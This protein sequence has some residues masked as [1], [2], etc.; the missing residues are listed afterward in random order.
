MTDEGCQT[1]ELDFP[2]S[3]PLPEQTATNVEMAQNGPEPTVTGEVVYDRQ[4]MVDHGIQGD[5]HNQW[6]TAAPASLP[7]FATNGSLSV[8]DSELPVPAGLVF[9][10]PSGDLEQGWHPRSPVLPSEGYQHTSEPLHAPHAFAGAFGDERPLETG[11]I[12]SVSHPRSPSEPNHLAVE[13]SGHATYDHLPT[14]EQNY[15]VPTAPQDMA[16]PPLD[17]ETEEGVSPAEQETST[18]YPPDYLDDD[19]PISRGVMDVEQNPFG[20]RPPVTADV[21]SSSWAPINNPTRATSMPRTD[22]LG[23]G[24]GQSPETAV[25][26]DE[27]DSD[28]DPPPPTAVEDTVVEGR[29]HALGVYEEAEVEDEVDAEYS[30]EDEPEYDADEMGGDYDTRNYVGPN[31][32]EDD[33]HDEDLRPHNLEPEFNDGESWEGVDEDEDEM[34]GADGEDYSEYESDYEMEYEMDEADENPQQP[35]RPVSQSTPQVIDLIS[36]SED[37][38]DDDQAAPPQPLPRTNI[39][40]PSRYQPKISDEVLARGGGDEESEE[41]EDSEG[42]NEEKDEAVGKEEH[43]GEQDDAESSHSSD[44]SELQSSAS[45]EASDD[46]VIDES[47]ETELEQAGDTPV[48]EVVEDPDMDPES[49]STEFQGQQA[50]ESTTEF[51]KSPQPNGVQLIAIQDDENDTAMGGVEDK[52][53]DE[54]IATPQ[55]AAEGLEFLSRIVEN[56]L[57]ANNETASSEKAQGETAVAATSSEADAPP[58]AHAQGTR[59]QVDGSQVTQEEEEQVDMISTLPNAPSALQPTV[60]DENKHTETVAPSSPPLTSSFVSQLGEES[61]VE[62]APQDAPPTTEPQIP[63]DQ[64]PTPLDTQLTGDFTV[65][66]PLSVSMEIEEPEEITTTTER[67]ETVVREVVTEQS[68]DVQEPLVTIEETITTL[69]E[70]EERPVEPVAVSRQQTPQQSEEIMESKSLFV[71]PSLSFQTQVDADDMTQASFTQP[72]PMPTVEAGAEAEADVHP[73]IEVNVSDASPSFQ[74]QMDLDEELQASIMEHSQVFDEDADIVTISKDETRDHIEDYESEVGI[75]QNGDEIEKEPEIEEI[76]SRAASPELGTPLEERRGIKR[77]ISEV[78]STDTTEL[79]SEADP[80]V[81]LARAANTSKRSA[82]ASKNVRTQKELLAHDIP[83]PEVED[84]SVQLARASLNKPPQAEEDS[85]SMTTAKLILIRH[86]RDELPDCTS[87]KVIRHHQQQKLDVIAVAM[88][89]PPDPQRAKGGP[90]EYMMSFTITDHSIGPYSVVE[91]Q[92][93]RPHK[94]SLPIIKAGDVVLL[95]NFTVVSLKG[96]DFGLRTNDESSWAVF[97]YEDG[98]PPQ[99]RGPPVEYGDKEATYVAHMRT[100]FNLLDEKARAKL[101]RANKKIVDAG[102]SK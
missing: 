45:E 44:Q 13:D 54:E 19:Q 85:S 6:S 66:D 53:E 63:A 81:Q 71:S 59:K 48:E 20:A 41:E 64:L 61:K 18:A 47:L 17:L 88:M 73:D 28:D 49:E 38:E 82:T 10:I 9:G 33:S 51:K 55:S 36:S 40:S 37:E 69:T 57:I 101:E 89:Q 21:V 58:I 92:L 26:I 32:D 83:T 74:S 102:K 8:S 67:V 3:M 22:R 87:L 16:Y 98:Q 84:S 42:S 5:V 11:D 23:S 77:A 7:L 60:T 99:I 50:D 94:D 75:S 100:W 39:P 93:Y 27:S 34:E 56:E 96:K 72:S 86:L 97:D 1:M 24:K 31:D 78:E 68:D 43:M 79:T 35:S 65:V 29:A 2:M 90:R 91:V 25:V 4:G 46:E 30:D 62:I 14:D 95:R 12:R 70:V 80:S 76:V 15:P 52:E